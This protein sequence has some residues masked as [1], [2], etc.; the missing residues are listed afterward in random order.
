MAAFPTRYSQYLY[1]ISFQEQAWAMS[2]GAG[3]KTQTGRMNKAVYSQGGV[4][5]GEIKGRIGFW[6]RP[7]RTAPVTNKEQKIQEKLQGRSFALKQR[8]ANGRFMSTGRAD[9]N[10]TR[11]AGKNRRSQSGLRVVNTGIPFLLLKTG[12]FNDGLTQ[13]RHHQIIDYE[14][15]MNPDYWGASIYRWFIFGHIHHETV[16]RVGIVY[17]ESFAQPVPGDAFAHTHFPAAPRRCRR[18]RC[19]P[20]AANT[21]N[22]R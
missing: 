12:P 16:K 20:T 21:A 8:G 22:I 9:L 7:K 4:F 5:F 3:R 10:I 18:S 14:G 15:A 11:G 13:T 1:H 17:C 2:R 19:M 6:A